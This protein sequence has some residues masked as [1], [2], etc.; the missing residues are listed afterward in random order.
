MQNKLKKLLL[1]VMSFI[2]LFSFSACSDIE[3]LLEIEDASEDEEVIDNKKYSMAG[4][5]AVAFPEDFEYPTT[6]NRI[7]GVILPETDIYAATIYMSQYRS[8]SY[9]F[10]NGSSLTINGN[11]YLTDGNG[12]D[13]D[14]DDG[15]RD[16]KITLW[17]KGTNAAIYIDT[18][19]FD[20]DGTNQTYTFTG[21]NPGGEYRIAI[22]YSD[23]W[24][25]YVSGNYN[26]SS[27]SGEGSEEETLAE[28]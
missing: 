2:M 22:T 13:A 5:S 18:A 9:L 17:E 20:A 19:H 26:I 15:Y 10:I 11:F 25:F 3:T 14:A 23:W 28:E 16:V 4:G 8:D 6:A 21:L 27:V 7:A 24:A 12:E 1:L